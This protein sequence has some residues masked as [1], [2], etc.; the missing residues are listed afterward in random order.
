GQLAPAGIVQAPLDL[1]PGMA[2]VV[3]GTVHDGLFEGRL[4]RAAFFMPLRDEGTPGRDRNS[5][6]GPLPGPER[7]QGVPAPWSA[8]PEGR[9]SGGADY[10][11]SLAFLGWLEGWTTGHAT[12]PDG[13]P[14]F[15]LGDL[16]RGSVCWMGP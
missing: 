5:P 14:G 1:G 9:S 3:Q 13:R 15:G 16:V 6:A 8:W 12:C 11:T 7:L 10:L 4:T 2:W